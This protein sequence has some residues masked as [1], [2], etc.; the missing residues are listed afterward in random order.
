[1]QTKARGALSL[2]TLVAAAAFALVAFATPSAYAQEEAAASSSAFKFLAAGIAFGLAALGAGFGGNEGVQ[3]DASHGAQ[4]RFN[5]A[6]RQRLLDAEQGIG[7]GEGLVL[8]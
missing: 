4:N 6:M 5:G 7:W 8:E 1:M 2:L 3:A